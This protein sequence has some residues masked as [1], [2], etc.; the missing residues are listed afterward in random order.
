[1]KTA[2]L[3]FT[4]LM[5]LIGFIVCSII[6]LSVAATMIG[7]MGPPLFIVLAIV[8]IVIAAIMGTHTHFSSRK[9]QHNGP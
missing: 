2:W 9:R 6:V 1:M 3:A 4:A 7:I 5:A 8:L